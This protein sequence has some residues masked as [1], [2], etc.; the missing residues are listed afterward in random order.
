MQLSKFHERFTLSNSIKISL[1]RRSSCLGSSFFSDFLKI[2]FDKY[3][4]SEMVGDLYNTYH[5]FPLIAERKDDQKRKIQTM[6]FV[7][8]SLLFLMQS[9]CSVQFLNL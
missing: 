8:F 6:R 2:T 1:T 9:I 4:K 3:H 5:L 7:C